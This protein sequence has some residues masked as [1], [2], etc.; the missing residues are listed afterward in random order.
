MNHTTSDLKASAPPVSAHSLQLQDPSLLRTQLY[1]HGQWVDGQAPSFTVFNPATAQPLACVANASTEQTQSA[2]RYG[3]QAWQDWRNTPAKQ[4]SAVLM[5]WFDLINQHA[6]DLARIITAEQGKPLREAQGEVAYAASF[7]EWFA[8]EAKRIYGETIPSTDPQKRLMVIKQS[9]G[10]CGAITPWNFPLAMIT[11]KVAPALAAGCSVVLKPAEQT[12]LTALACAELADRAGFA[13]GL[14]NVLTASAQQSPLIGQTL[15]A[16]PIVRHM[17]F[18]GSTEVG[19]I[20][21]QQC[22]PTIKKLSLELG[23]NAPFLVFDDADL[24]QAVAGAMS[25]KYRNAG[26]TCVCTNRFLVQDGIYDAFVQ[27]LAAQAQ[28][29]KAGDGL[30]PSTTLGPLINAE[31]MAKVQ[32]H[33]ADAQAQGAQIITGGHPLGPRHYAPTVLANVKPEMLCI[34]EETFGPIAPIMRFKTEAQAIELANHTQYGLASYVYSRDLGR[35][36]RVAEALEYGMVG[37]NTGLISATE[38]PFGG[39]K[40]SGLGREGSRHG[41][42]EYLEMKYLCLSL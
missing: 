18:T 1:L 35:I 39:I 4:R 20:L 14:F 33:V 31:A 8:E 16:S 41:L 22:A 27:K 36:Y 7:V 13:P 6:H 32:S 34:Q 28:T 11:R 15:C 10:V 26:Q 42:E 30:D 12:P 21:M 23:G 40:Q 9:I 29:L 17:S 2:I 37:I 38:A 24:D 5:R 3:Q 25:S 19:R